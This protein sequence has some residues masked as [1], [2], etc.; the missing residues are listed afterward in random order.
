MKPLPITVIMLVHRNDENL[1][2]ALESARFASEIIVVDN[3]SGVE[4]QQFSD[5]PLKILSEKEHITDFSKVRNKAAKEANNEWI[6]FLDSDEEIIQP[7]IPK[8]AAILASPTAA[9][10]VVFRSDVFHGKKLSFGEA[11][12][13]QLLRIGKKNNIHFSGKVHEV[14]SVNGELLYSRIELQH[15]AHPSISE[16]IMD[17]SGYAQVVAA[18]KTTTFG[19]N[20]LEMLIFPLAKCMYSLFIQGG[21]ADG[22]R[23]VVYAA[24][25]SLHSLLVRIYRYELLANAHKHT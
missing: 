1:K 14:A 6:F 19:N 20:L 2:K 8:L 18:T 13:Q 23:G 25:M 12:H 21:I 24:C 22:W 15:H 16:F 5:L 17:V 3:R 10:A 4:W 9:G 7:I 11:G